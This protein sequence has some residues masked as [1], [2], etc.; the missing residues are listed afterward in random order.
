MPCSAG[1]GAFMVP[2]AVPA[3]SA[4]K[5]PTSFTFLEQ[6]WSPQGAKNTAGADAF[7]AFMYSDAAIDIFAKYGAV[8]PVA[9]IADKLEGDNKTFYSIYDN[10]ATAVMGGFVATTDAGVTP[11]DAY[12]T[13]VNQLVAGDITVDEWLAG[14]KD[15]NTALGAAVISA[16]EEATDAAA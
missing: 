7:I 11:A 8:Q 12:F 10:G 6:I 15:A 9:G 14:I 2:A 4:D 5:N 3:V 16:S 1:E 13:P